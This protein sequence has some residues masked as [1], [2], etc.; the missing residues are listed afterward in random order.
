MIGVAFKWNFPVIQT[1]NHFTGYFRSQASSCEI[2]QV[3]LLFSKNAAPKDDRAVMDHMMLKFK[4][5]L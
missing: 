1:H 5:Y 3:L 4:N 2:E